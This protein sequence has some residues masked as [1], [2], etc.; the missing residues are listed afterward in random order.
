VALKSE[1]PKN[2]KSNEWSIRQAAIH[3]Q[4]DI[5]YGPALWIVT[6][7]NKDIKERF[8]ELTGKYGDDARM[9]REVDAQL[10]NKYTL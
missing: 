7:G 8:K 6:K 9:S 10:C 1:D 2:I 4:F 5:V 3:H